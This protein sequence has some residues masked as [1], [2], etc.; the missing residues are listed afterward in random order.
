LSRY[1][2]GKRESHGSTRLGRDGEFQNIARVGIHGGISIGTWWNRG[3]EAALKTKKTHIVNNINRHRL[4]LVE[5]DI[6]AIG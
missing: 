5:E 3:R 1:R 6:M 2:Q 4:W